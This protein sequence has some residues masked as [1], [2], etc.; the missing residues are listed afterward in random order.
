MFGIGSKGVAEK[1]GCLTIPWRW[2]SYRLGPRGV[3][4]AQVIPWVP[5]V[6]EDL[7]QATDDRED[8][9]G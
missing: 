4:P 6:H 5:N 1:N 2:L 9:E 8:S 3:H 7:L